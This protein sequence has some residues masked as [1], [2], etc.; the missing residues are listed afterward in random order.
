MLIRLPIAL[1][2]PFVMDLLS[3]PQGLAALMFGWKHCVGTSTLCAQQKTTLVPR[4]TFHCHT[5]APVMRDA[6]QYRQL[7]PQQLRLT[8]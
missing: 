8:N 2:K 4:G 7:V 6:G 5:P 1:R 3:S